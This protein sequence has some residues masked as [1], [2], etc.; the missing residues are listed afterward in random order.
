MDVPIPTPSDPQLF[1]DELGKK[2]RLAGVD[3]DGGR[4][5]VPELVDPAK[6]PRLVWA[7]EDELRAVVGRLVPFGGAA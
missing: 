1:V 5:F 6:T 4:R 3:P 7:H 2:W